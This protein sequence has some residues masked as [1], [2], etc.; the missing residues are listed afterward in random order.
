MEDLL[1]S[2]ASYH[3]PIPRRALRV[4]DKIMKNIERL[5]QFFSHVQL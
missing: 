4:K 3:I 2:A 1:T 5:E